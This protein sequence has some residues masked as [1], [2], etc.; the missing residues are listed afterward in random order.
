MDWIKRILKRRSGSLAEF[1]RRIGY[2]FRDPRLLEKALTHRSWTGQ[3]ADS[4]RQDSNERLEFLGDAV[5]DLAVSHYLYSRFPSKKEGELTKYKSIVVSGRFLVR[6]ARNI[7][8]GEQLLLSES[9]DRTGGRQRESILEDAFEAMLGAVFLDGGLKAATG[10]V[11]RL[12]LDNLDLKQ[13]TRQNR[14]YKSLLLELSQRWGLG[15]P[16]YELLEEHGP[17]HSKF[18]VI[19]AQVEGRPVGHGTGSSKKRAEQAAADQGFNRLKKLSL[20]EWQQ[21]AGTLPAEEEQ[22][23]SDEVQ[24]A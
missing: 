11:D 3:Q 1:E 14:N 10:L 16:H 23:E 2:C 6:I 18:F 8:L 12:V 21:G 19:E 13:A 4:T 9:E 5:L 17:D 24:D 22:P 20:E 7:G 15:I